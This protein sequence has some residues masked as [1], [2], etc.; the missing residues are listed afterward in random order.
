MSY[1]KSSYY[2]TGIDRNW[3]DVLLY[4]KPKNEEMVK[5]TKLTETKKDK[6]FKKWDE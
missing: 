6:D 2:D 3:F 5:T 4:V 1:K